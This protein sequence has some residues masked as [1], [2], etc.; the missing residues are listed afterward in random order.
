MTLLLDARGL[1]IHGRLSPTDLTVCEGELIALV[2]PNGGGKT[3]LLRALAGV[4]D[5]RGQVT[6]AGQH[7]ASAPPARR[8]RLLAFLPASRDIVWPIAARDL[9][10]LGLRAPDEQRIELLLDLL[11]LRPL[12][13]RPV[14]H[15]STGERSRVLFARTL[16]AR[17][18]LLLLDEP[19]A[20]LDP[21]WVLRTLEILCEAVES[22]GC[23]AL[24]SL[25]DL[26][27]MEA[28]D[29]VLLV[30]SGRI[31]ADLDPARMLGSDELSEAF[32]IE[33][34]GPGWR[35]SRPEDRRSLQ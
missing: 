33:R 22:D 9:I 8:S 7:I 29:R 15:L 30:D 21:F 13:R 28:F 17:P 4:E 18:R 2:G 12:E 32:R 20:N 26:S 31:L 16:A 34:D 1:T 5:S 19:L 25:H 6:I 35:V 11:E 14:S 10:S 27:Q 3:S 24:L 23:A